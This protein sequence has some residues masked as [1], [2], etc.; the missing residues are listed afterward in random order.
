VVAVRARHRGVRGRV[1]LA[2]A[3]GTAVRGAGLWRRLAAA[4]TRGEAAARAD[5]ERVLLEADLGPAAVDEILA[6]VGR[7]PRTGAGGAGGGSRGGAGPADGGRS[8][9]HR[10]RRPWCWSTA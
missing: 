2:A 5:A 3:R 1:V 4:F 8:R 10:P 9:A 7:R 6:A